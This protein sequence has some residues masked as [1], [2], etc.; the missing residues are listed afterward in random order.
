M[1]FTVEPAIE[2]DLPIVDPHHHL[3]AT[4]PGSLYR[5]FP[6]ETLAKERAESGHN[7]VSTVFVDCHRGYLTGGPDELKPIGETRAVEADAK[8]AEAAGGNMKGLCAGI[9]SHADM[10]LGAGIE[11]VLQ[12]HLAE[13]PTRFRGIRHHSPH[14]P[15]YQM[16]GT[17]STPEDLRR[18]AWTEGLKVLTR[19]GLSFD[20]WLYFTQLADVAYIAKKVPDAT[21]ILDHIGT[22]LPLPD[23]SPEQTKEMWRKGIREVAACPNVVVKVG[24][25]MMFHPKVEKELSSEQAAA[26]MRDY[27]LET[28][29]VFGPDRCMME[30]N[31]PVCA[32][33]ISYGNL[34]NAYKRITA[35]FSRAEK[36]AMYAG[37][38]KSTYKI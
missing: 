36:E 23:I 32:L 25:L 15:T 11:R 29:N 16:F 18:P 4:G 14:H 17:A 13:S 1:E 27:F 2:P 10:N 24:G 9:V 35:S 31:F 19:L 12:A 3:W 7:I 37:V 20:S 6:I 5:A 30:S 26:F 38:A 28:I 8:K 33:A 21:I 22:P 34:W